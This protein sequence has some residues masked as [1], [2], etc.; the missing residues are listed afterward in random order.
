LADRDHIQR[1]LDLLI[2]LDHLADVTA[3]KTGYGGRPKVSYWI[4]PVS[5]GQS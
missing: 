5:R 2:E 1:G 4:N 3:G